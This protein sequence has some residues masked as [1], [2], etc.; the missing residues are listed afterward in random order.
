MPYALV[1]YLEPIGSPGALGHEEAAHAHAAFLNLVRG[2]DPVLS[3]RLHA[4]NERKPFSVWMLAASDPRTRERR[5]ALRLTLL[6]DSL[7]A[8]IVGS[9][10]RDEAT[11]LRLGPN[12]YRI[13]ELATHPSAHHLAGFGAYA[14]LMDQTLAP[15]RLIVRFV[16]PTAFRSQDRDVLW[17]DPRLVWQSW[18]RTWNAHCEPDQRFGEAA[19][20]GE[21]VTGVTVR[22]HEVR[23]RRVRV[24]EGVF[25]GFTGVAEYDLAR[26]PEPGRRWLAVLARFSFFSGTGRKTTMGL[27][28]T[29]PS[30]L[31]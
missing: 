12:R 26:V 13:T 31:T 15:G 28:Q 16:S 11:T 30:N 20:L 1:A 7:F 18:V 8:P 3:E 14:E 2:I 6:D 17:P 25:A 9:L 22:R 29:R 27:G 4:D 24:S 23:T 5:P 19:L 21:Y 10:L